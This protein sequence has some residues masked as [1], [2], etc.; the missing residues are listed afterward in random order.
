MEVNISLSKYKSL[1]LLSFIC[2]ICC[3]LMVGFFIGLGYYI[4]YQSQAKANQIFDELNEKAKYQSLSEKEKLITLAKDVFERF[5][6]DGSQSNI[7]LRLRPYLTAPF[8]PDFI[9][10]RDGAIDLYVQEG[11]CDNSARILEYL[12]AQEGYESRQWD[13]VTSRSAHSALAISLKDGREILM[14]TFF[15][16]YPEINGELVSA[17]KAKIALDRGGNIDDI[18]IPLNENGDSD[19]YTHLSATSMAGDGDAFKIVSTIPE[20]KGQKLSL[21]QV[22]GSYQDVANESLLLDMTP[23]WHYMGSRY[24]R[25]WVRVL[26]ASEDVRVTIEMVDDIDMGVVTAKPAP[27]ILEK[28]LI[29]NLKQGDQIIFVDGDAERS[30]TRM[31][32]YQSVDRFLFEKIN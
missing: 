9:R 16:V 4:E 31:N 6:I 26:H 8:L 13:M 32:S 29:W 3:V 10:V 19:F 20:I 25:N 15:G 12:L 30:W 22:D 14:D 28:K 23:Y 18:F 21:G 17:H 27:Q 2:V 7:L 11:I 5:E 24:N 1:K